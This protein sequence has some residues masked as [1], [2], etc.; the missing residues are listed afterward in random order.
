MSI[1]TGINSNMHTTDQRKML[2]AFIRFHRERLSPPSPGGRRRTPGLRREELSDAAGLGL[3]WITWLEQGREVTASVAALCR[4]SDALHLSVAERASLFDLAGKMDPKSRPEP[5]DEL[6]ADLMALPALMLVPAYLLDHSW[7]AKAWNQ[8]AARL[9]VGWLDES[10]ADRNLLR[11]VFLSS[12]AHLLIADWETRAERL[13]AEFR[14]DFNRRPGDAERMA[15]VQQL[16]TESALFAR[17][18]RKHDVL[19]REGGERLFN[20]PQMGP[21]QFSQTTLQVA[22]QPEIK[23]VCLSPR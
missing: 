5:I 22:L 19:H 8:A 18:W 17:L 10:A 21:L 23:L 13:V 11:Y 20:H 1:Y 12:H 2:G 6:A 16:K 7:N 15:I 3:T 14:A 4:L 9:F